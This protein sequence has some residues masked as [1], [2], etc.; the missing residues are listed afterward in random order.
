M[1][2]YLQSRRKFLVIVLGITVFAFV[3]A[4]FVGWGSYSYGSKSGAIA[5]VGDEKITFLQYQQAYT[6]LHNIYSQF[7][8]N[9]IEPA[10]ENELK[11]VALNGLINESLLVSFAKDLGL[12]V[13]A[14]E[15]QAKILTIEAFKQDGK[16][17][18]DLYVSA[19]RN[20]RNEIKD[21][22]ADLAHQLLIEKLSKF[23][24]MPATKSEIDS[25]AAT[26]F[27]QDRLEMKVIEAPKTV[28][29]SHEEA[30]KHYEANRFN[31]M[32]EAKYD[33]T[34]TKVELKGYAA[35]AEEAKEYYDKNRG[36]FLSSEG[37]VQAYDQVSTAA[38]KGAKM[39]K[40][41][42]DALREKIALRDG[43]IAGTTLANLNFTNDKLS[44]EVMQALEAGQNKGVLDPIAVEDGYVIAKLDKRYAPEPK[45]FE[46][47]YKMIEGEIRVQ[48]IMALVDEMAQKELAS[49]KGKDI[50]FISR[51]DADKLTQLNPHEAEQVV[52]Q[53]FGSTEQ[54]GVINLGNRAV[55]YKIVEQ[56]L[57]DQ[58]KRSEAEKMLE[59]NIARLK[60]S[61][62][63]QGLLE[64]LKARY[65][66]TVY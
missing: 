18:K 59:E 28:A 27:M 41:R 11:Q 6:S 65:K 49:F 13:S 17:S 53:I 40:A 38:L 30:K 23:I 9:G 66:I 55:L 57:F 29:V 2:A 20:T 3:G 50:G 26:M 63:Q 47:A 33:V 35:T 62:V 12:K 36:E 61:Q 24:N 52:D 22:E 44:L 48:K 19:I 39:A 1:I 34:Y 25:L 42:R 60:L 5:T 7:Y 4:G 21:F 54:K 10:M 31:Y 8:E 37:T 64:Q 43:K 14:D 45:S 46:E 16:F 15:V 58:S 56:K 51:A 32:G